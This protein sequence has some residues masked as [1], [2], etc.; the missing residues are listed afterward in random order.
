M[1]IPVLFGV[2]VVVFICLH[3]A[4]GNPAQLLLG[5]MAT[6][7]ELHALT[8]EL[9]LNKPLVVQF[10]DWFSALLTGNLGWSVQFHQSV[11]SLIFPK[12]LNTLILTVTAFVISSVAGIFAGLVGGLWHGKWIDHVFNVL[13]FMALS[14]PVFWLGQLLI[15]VLGLHF[16]LFPIEGMYAI[17][18]NE[19]VSTLAHHLALPALALAAAPGAVIAQITRVAFIDELKQQYMLTARSKGLMYIQAALLHALRN[20]WI[21]IVTTLGLEINYLIGGD[22]LIEN[23]FSWPGIG[24][25]LVQ[26]V[27]SRDYPVIL[28]STI[29]LAVIF[30]VVNFLVDALYPMLNPRVDANE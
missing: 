27:L 24:Q 1:L 18:S 7:A 25:L 20:A 13:N 22:V 3:L 28:G 4:P 16:H 12:L 2:A 5:P 30:V 14:L 11:N 10:W 29:V 26:S 21:P 17:G 9:G 6:P 15:M 23:V 19:T 8:V